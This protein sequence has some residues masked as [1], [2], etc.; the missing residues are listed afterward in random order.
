M[1]EFEAAYHAWLE[2][3]MKKSPS[4][5]KLRTEL[6]KLISVLKRLKSIYPAATLHDCVEDMEDHPVRLGNTNLGIF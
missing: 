5:S 6:N 3:K 4:P 2:A 1:A